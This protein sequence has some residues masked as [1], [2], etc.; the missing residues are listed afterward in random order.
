LLYGVTDERFWHLNPKKLSYYK[1]AYEKRL[2]IESYGRWEQG[3]YFREAVVSALSKHEYPKHPYGF[4]K[5]LDEEKEERE[6]TE[7]EKQKA[8][9]QFVQSMLIMQ[10]RWE[11]DK[12]RK[13]LAENQNVSN[14][15]E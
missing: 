5:K 15:T 12:I 14:V 7:E 4:D 11:R 6:Y 13:E 2:E 8:R 9:D 1:K 10:G 3:M